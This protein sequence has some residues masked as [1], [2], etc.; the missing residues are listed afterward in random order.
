MVWLVNE[1]GRATP[2]VWKTVDSSRVKHRRAGYED[3][4]LWM[5]H[6]ALPDGVRVT[7]LADRGFGDRGLYALLAEKLRF[8]FVVRFKGAVVVESE[9]GEVRPAA[10]WVPS[11]GQA[12]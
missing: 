4:V 3:D 12:R 11:N 8:D 5:L 1:H 7:V 6:G 10:D 9:S 2:L